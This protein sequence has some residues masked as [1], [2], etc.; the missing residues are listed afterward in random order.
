MNFSKSQLVYCLMNAH[1]E[2]RDI[3]RYLQASFG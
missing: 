1:F 2:S 3:V